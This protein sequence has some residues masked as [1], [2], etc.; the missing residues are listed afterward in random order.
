MKQPRSVF[1]SA[2]IIVSLLT[3]C[4]CTDIRNRVFPDVLAVD[5]GTPAEFTAHLTQGGSLLSASADSPLL[6]PDALQN[7]SGAE[8]SEEHLSL[9]AFSGN[10]CGLVSGYFAK[11]WLAPDCPVLYVPHSAC[12]ALKAGTLPTA[13]QISAAVSSGRLPCRTAD[14]V[15]GDLL[16]GSGVTALYCRDGSGLSL[17]LADRDGI[18]GKLSED[19]CRG[20][21]LLCGRSDHFSFAEAGAV[22]TVTRR[23]AHILASEDGD[24]LRFT[25]SADIF[26]ET[27]V[28]DLAASALR[29]MLDAALT[30]TAAD[31]GADLLFL[32]ESAVRS[33]IPSASD[34]SAEAW[35]QTLLSADYETE[36]RLHAAGNR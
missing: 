19:A 3:L 22:C 4:G 9:L 36:L 10:P 13:A 21:A 25:L 27:D 18:T 14:A 7:A 16:G 12:S 31:A 8:I 20:L 11:Q 23:K 32:R 28:P 17:V 5:C 6:M 34:D 15:L 30:E 2:I 33:G 35:R 1:I 26:C 29:R 24:R